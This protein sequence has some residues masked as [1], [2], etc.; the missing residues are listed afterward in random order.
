MTSVDVP[1]SASAFYKTLHATVMEFMTSQK[2]EPD[3][4]HRLDHDRMRAIRTETGSEHSWGHNYLVR[5]HPQLAPLPDADAFIAHLTRMCP[6]LD[7]WETTVTDIIIDEA[8]KVAIVRASYYMEPKDSGEKVEN[9]LLWYLAMNEDG[10]KVK[11][12]V[13]FL[14]GAAMGRIMQLMMGGG[15]A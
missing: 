14:D 3:M 8:K 6:N 2:Q 9:D 4:P 13:E 15:K 7:S 1:S 5:Q 12:S 11:K 10:T